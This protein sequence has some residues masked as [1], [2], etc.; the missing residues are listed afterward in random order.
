MV[1]RRCLVTTYDTPTI[2]R[3]DESVIPVYGQ[4]S[5]AAELVDV[6]PIWQARKG[7]Q[8]LLTVPQGLFTG[9]V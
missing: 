9:V 1:I 2:L 7:R 4:F 8:C 5:E 3:R 6:V